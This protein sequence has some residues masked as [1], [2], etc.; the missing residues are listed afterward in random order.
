MQLPV[1]IRRLAFRIVYRLL[2]V[3]WFVRRPRLRGVKCLLTDGDRVLLVRHTYGPHEWE[4][5]GGGIK[6]REPP[7][8]AA[9]R[10]MR[11]ELGIDVEQ[12]TDV[13]ELDVTIRN[14]HGILNCFH[15]ARPAAPIEPDPGELAAATW[16][17]PAELPP[18]LGPYVNAIIARARASSAG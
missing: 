6:R 11:E 15:A 10:E 16:F 5:P 7:S 12:W 18:N 3:Y 9:R 14:R 2:R 8:S 4:V 1:A 17:A 13:G